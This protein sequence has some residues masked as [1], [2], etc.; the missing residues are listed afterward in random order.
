MKTFN[1]EVGK[2][3]LNCQGDTCVVLDLDYNGKVLVKHL[4]LGKSVLETHNIDGSLFSHL[5]NYGPDGVFGKCPYDIIKEK[6]KTLKYSAYAVLYKTHDGTINYWGLYDI[7]TNNE[8]DI[9]RIVEII[10]DAGY[11]FY[12]T[13]K[14]DC[15]SDG[16]KKKLNF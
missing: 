16:T 13:W 9:D 7:E 8:T 3:Y 1:F 2:E 4:R 6:P 5:E 12:G 14:I 15:E 10:I 11:E